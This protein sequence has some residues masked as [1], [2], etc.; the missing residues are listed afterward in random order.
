[1]AEHPAPSPT[2]E[3]AAAKTAFIVGEPASASPAPA[4]RTVVMPLLAAAMI[5]MT[6]TSKH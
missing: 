5:V 1:M 3:A 6:V 4:G 2:E